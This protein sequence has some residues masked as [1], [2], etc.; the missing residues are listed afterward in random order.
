MA[1]ASAA[2]RQH[3]PPILSFHSRPKSVCF[4]ALAVIWLKCAFRHLTL[5]N[6]RNAASAGARLAIKFEYTIH[7]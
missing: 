3:G 7:F 1:A 5:L 4:G 2:P 6:A